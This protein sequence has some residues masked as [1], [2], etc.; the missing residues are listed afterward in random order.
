MDPPCATE[1]SMWA[2]CKRDPKYKSTLT[3]TKFLQRQKGDLTI[4]YDVL[5]AY[6]NNY[7][8]QVTMEN[9]SPLG[10]LDRWNLTWEWT[11]GEF[12]SSMKGAFTRE[13]D[14]SD[15]IY[16]VAG[17]YYKDMDFSKVI[18]CQK[19]PVLSDLPPEKYNDTEI[20]KIP[21]CCRNGSLLPTLMDASQ[22][23]SVF[24]MQVFKVPPDMNKTAI[25]PPEKWKIMGI[26]NPDYKCGSPLK[27]EP[28]R[29]PD[30]RGLD[31]TVVSIASW[32][33]ACN[34]TEP[35]K[36]NTR[37]CVSFS[38]YYNESIVP[39][40]TCACGCDNINTDHCNPDARAMLLPPEALLVP[41]ENR[42]L[43]TIAW[44]KLKHFRVPKKLPCG[45]N[46]GV[47]INWHIASDFKGGWSARI[48]IFNWK[49]M[50]FE[51]WFTALQF[52]KRVSLGFEKV[53][54]FNGTIL[55]RLNNT[56]FMQGLKGTNYLL[57]EDN[58]T[59]PKV[60][61]K[62]QSVISFTKKYKMDIQIA[63]GD[64]FPTKV[65]FNGEECSIPTQF[66]VQSGTLNNVGDL[67]HKLLVL[68][69]TFFTMN[70]ILY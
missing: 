59:N 64:G 49:P 67:V 47:S 48:T 45:D 46:C 26:L 44:A 28:S 66:P 58:G 3:K 57:G 63:K 19:N 15:C 22:S 60:A 27:V 38:S 34:I 70:Q 8:V 61:G 18:N 43:K 1:S 37:C 5:Q 24:Q 25:Y 40:N 55:P 20:G 62:Q 41:F 9:N 21:F 17:D 68:V 50:N 2:C 23:K 35:T 6:E 13:I 39:C 51:N 42:T 10:R 36:R 7:L 33:I 54:S 29:Y 12:I 69:L 52:K 16:G 32:Q 31:A 11:R 30:T 56:I 53:Y 14:Y 65:L 4:S